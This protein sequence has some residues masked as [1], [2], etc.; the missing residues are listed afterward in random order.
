[1]ITEPHRVAQ[2]PGPTGRREPADAVD[3]RA[4]RRAEEAVLGKVA[5][6]MDADRGRPKAAPGPTIIGGGCNCGLV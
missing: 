6:Y 1:M 5:A 4:G 2:S 3:P